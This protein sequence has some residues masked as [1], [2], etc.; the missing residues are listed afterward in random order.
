MS[1]TRDKELWLI[2]TDPDYPSQEGTRR[3]LETSILNWVK[4]VESKGAVTAPSELCYHIVKV[5]QNKRGKS[6]Y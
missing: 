3:I 5:K 6:R 2:T 1:G 4:I